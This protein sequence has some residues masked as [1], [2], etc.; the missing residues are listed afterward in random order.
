MAGGGRADDDDD[1]DAAADAAV[2]DTST[3][4][5]FFSDVG[6][7]CP[8]EAEGLDPVGVPGRGF[9][10]GWVET[11]SCRVRR[12]GNRSASASDLTTAALRKPGLA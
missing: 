5:G 4:V 11:Q 12:S 2:G 8:A 9:R 6:R 7:P 10:K 3:S 1:C